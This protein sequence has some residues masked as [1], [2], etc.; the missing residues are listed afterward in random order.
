MTPKMLVSKIRTIGRMSQ[1]E[2]AEAAG[3]PQ[4]M[5]SKLERGTVTDIMSKSYVALMELYVSLQDMEKERRG[6]VSRL[7]AKK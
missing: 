5:I 4:S 3:V 6:F 7:T 1:S 2:V